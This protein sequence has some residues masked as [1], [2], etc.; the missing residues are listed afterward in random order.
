MTDPPTDPSVFEEP[1]LSRLPHSPDPSERINDFRL[2]TKDSDLADMSVYDEPGY[3]G[4]IPQG[5][6]TYWS[7]VEKKN[8]ET[9]LGASLGM[10]LL[11]V[12]AAGPWAV[13]GALL[14]GGTLD[15]EGVPML[16]ALCLVAPVVEEMMKVS[17]ALYVV[18]RRPF[19]FKA[20][21]QI[22]LCAVSGGLVFGILENLIYLNVYFEDPSP[23][24]E[25]WRWIVCTGLHVTCSTLAGFG[26]V[27]VWRDHRDRKKRPEIT[28]A[29]PFL[30]AAMVVHGAYNGFAILLA[31]TGFE[32]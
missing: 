3:T 31:I 32:F 17:A 7:W 20:S 28:V 16:L 5:A 13:L 9:T 22:L 24:L 6:F 12:L 29:Y 11:L 23:F 19:Y 25:R 10:T 26:L 27:R 8:S 4:S 18:E 1:H 15:F 2:S 30:I 14:Q 21:W